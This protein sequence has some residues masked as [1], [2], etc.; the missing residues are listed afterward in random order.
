LIAS[1]CQGLLQAGLP[2][3]GVDGLRFAGMENAC[4]DGGAG[5]EKA[6]GQKRILA[7]V[8]Y[9]QFAD[10]AGTIY[11]LDAVREDPG[12]SRAH[13]G[14]RRGGDAQPQTRG[15]RGV[16]CICTGTLWLF[17]RLQVLKGFWMTRKAK[18]ERRP[19]DWQ[20]AIQ[21]AISLRYDG[22]RSVQG[23]GTSPC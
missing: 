17:G 1:P 12:M 8:D 3:S 6:D 9:C 10:L 14:F 5:I 13:G 16:A 21:Q 23:A 7:V 4:A 19:A 2:P 22:Q 11:L 15:W 20:S 18:D